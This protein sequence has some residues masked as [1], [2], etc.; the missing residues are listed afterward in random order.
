MGKTIAPNKGRPQLHSSNTC[1]PSPDGYWSTIPMF[2]KIKIQRK[3]LGQTRG[4]GKL[5]TQPTRVSRTRFGERDGSIR[6]ELGRKLDPP[7]GSGTSQLVV[8]RW[9]GSR[10]TIGGN[11]QPRANMSDAWSG[12]ISISSGSSWN[13]AHPQEQGSGKLDALPVGQIKRITQHQTNGSCRL[14]WTRWSDFP[15]HKFLPKLNVFR[16]A[17]ETPLTLRFPSAMAVTLHDHQINLESFV[18]D[19]HFFNGLLVANWNFL[20]GY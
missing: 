1:L 11:V 17:V 19:C 12:T 15:R 9:K 6:Y 20:T 2:W 18:A 16:R 4:S 7:F 5:C 14:S 10:T 8:H 3:T 13:T